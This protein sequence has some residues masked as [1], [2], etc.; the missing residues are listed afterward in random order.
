MV[1]H[2]LYISWISYA[3]SLNG[4]Q[5]DYCNVE[6]SKKPFMMTITFTLNQ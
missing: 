3:L 5:G 2:L 1:Y 4:G 6:I